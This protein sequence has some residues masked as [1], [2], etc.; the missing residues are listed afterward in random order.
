VKKAIFL[1]LALVLCLSLCACGGTPEIEMADSYM[2]NDET[3][4]A[5]FRNEGKT[6]VTYVKGNLNLFGGS[7]NSQS[8][9]GVASFEW[10]GTCEKGKTFKVTAKVNNPKEGLADSVNRIGI[11]IF[12]IK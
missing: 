10:S 9:I 8:S 11:S 7:A 12:E 5:T 3:V 2:T 1:F 6:T 4:I